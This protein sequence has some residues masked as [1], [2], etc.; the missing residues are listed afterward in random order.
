MKKTCYISITETFNRI[1]AVDVDDVNAAMELAE[2][3]CRVGLIELNSEDFV[4]REV[5]DLTEDINSAIKEGY[6]EADRYEKIIK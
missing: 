1:V 5:E 4:A 3:A 2:H 6:I